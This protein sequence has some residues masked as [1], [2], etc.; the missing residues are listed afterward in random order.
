MDFAVCSSSSHLRRWCRGGTGSASCALLRFVFSF[1]FEKLRFAFSTAN[2]I[3]PWT[4]RAKKDLTKCT[5]KIHSGLQL[6]EYIYPRFSNFRLQVALAFGDE[7]P[8][9]CFTAARSPP[10]FVVTGLIYRLPI[11]CA[12][13]STGKVV[14]VINFLK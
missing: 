7:H 5:W 2:A 10:L 3:S 6:A 8:V 14:V 12:F 13:T 11:N 4:W 1:Y 9:A